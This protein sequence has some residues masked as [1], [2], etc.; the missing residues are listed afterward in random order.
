MGK[1][2]ASRQAPRRRAF[3]PAAIAVAAAAFAAFLPAL[4]NGFVWDDMVYVQGNALLRAPFVS[5][6]RQALTVVLMGNYH[7]VTVVSLV[8]DYA[9]GGPDPFLFHL[10]NLAIHAANAALLYV[11][12]RELIAPGLGALA[13]ALLWAVHPLRVESVAWISGRKDLLYVLF[14]LLAL[15]AYL[16]HARGDGRLGRAYAASLALF[17]AALLSK[18]MAVSLVPVLFLVDWLRGRPFARRSIVEKLPFIVLALAAGLVA[19]WA[20]KQVGA[21]PLDQDIGPLGRLAYACYG[22]VFYLVKTVAPVRLSAFYPY[23]HGS[24][25]G[26]APAVVAAVIAVAALAALVV[27]SLRRSRIPAFAAGFYL[28]TVALVLQVLPVG[29][30]VAADRYTYLPAVG[31]SCLAA[32]GLA[33]ASARGR[34][35][36]AAI[37]GVAFVL[38]A[39]SW[40][41]CAVWKDEIALW[42][43]V[44]S[45]HDDVTLAHQNRGIAT[46]ER[47]DLRE[48]LSD[49]DRAIALNPGYAEVWWNRANVLAALDRR[50]RALADYREAIRLDPEAAKYRFN[51]GLVLGD[52]G[53]WD[54]AIAALGDAVRLKP[55][56]AEAYLN[57]GLALEQAGRAAEGAPDVRR[58]A[59]LGYPVDPAVLARFAAAPSR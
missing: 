8:V 27:R 23:P 21:V 18:A 25:G 11:V 36:M 53:R 54:D 49:F 42:N 59:Q 7:P 50:D 38:G 24:S 5:A 57:R 19:V 13:G 2:T 46:A 12:L 29:G 30:A 45:K 28:A 22:L 58:A 48:A 37:V 1:K 4:S 16:R 41:R 43:D 32:A 47:G 15:L 6:L 44:L 56:F 14:V 26:L 55:D 3:D 17:V 34:P 51:Y 31:L 40:A 52:E 9:V 39:A 33:R 35:W 20:Q 10:V